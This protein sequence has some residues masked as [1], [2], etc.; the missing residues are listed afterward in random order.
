MVDKNSFDGAQDAASATREAVDA[1]TDYIGKG[2]D[3]AHEYGSRGYSA[4]RQY[5][6]NASEYANDGYDAARDY[7]SAGLDV[8]SRMTNDLTD[9]VRKEPWIAIAAAFAIGYVAARIV[10]RLSI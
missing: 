2:V 9:F 7:A 3:A 5:A 1:V 8:A 4:A 6:D 10:R